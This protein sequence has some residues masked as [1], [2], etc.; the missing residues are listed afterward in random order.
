MKFNVETP[1][2]LFDVLCARLQPMSRS[3]VR[4]LLKYGAVSL[5]GRITTRSDVA[6]TPGQSIEIQKN[7]GAARSGPPFPILFEDR[8]VMAVVK[9]AGLLSIATKNERE[10][11]LYRSLLRYVQDQ[12]QGRDRIFIVHRLDREV[13]GIMV[14]AKTAKA[15]EVLQK[16]W[17]NAEKL[18]CALVEGHPP[19]ESGTLRSWLRENRAHHVFE[20]T[21]GPEAKLSITHYR[22]LRAMPKYTLLEV[23]LETGRKHQIRVHLAGMGCPVAGDKRYGALNDPIRQLGLCAYALAFDHPVTRKRIKLAIPIPTG[24]QQFQGRR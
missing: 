9:P 1:D 16:N 3:S 2:S 21:P 11:T 23:R 5:D 4:K 13:S 15:Q 7:R 8:H 20:T 22:Q 6:V 14:F 19:E 18:Y 24:M 17:S 12:S 10:R